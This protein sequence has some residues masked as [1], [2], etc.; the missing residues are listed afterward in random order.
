MYQINGSSYPD[1]ASGRSSR[2]NLSFPAYL[3]LRG[4]AGDAAD[5][6]AC[7]FVGEANI[8]LGAQRADVVWLILRQTV[9][10]TAIGLAIGIPLAIAA[11]KTVASLLYGVKPTDPASLVIAAVAMALVAAVAAYAPARRA[12]RLEPLA[13]LRVD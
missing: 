11:A 2:A 4:A 6:F 13:A 5:V 1:P 8:A 3:P 12:A 7:S 9:V 10:V